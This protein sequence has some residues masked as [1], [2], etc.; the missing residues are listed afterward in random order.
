M[1]A[2][3]LRATRLIILGMGVALC[4]VSILHPTWHADGSRSQMASWLWAAPSGPPGLD[5]VVDWMGT[6]TRITGIMIG[7]AL[8]WW[9]I[10]FQIY[11][12]EN[13]HPPSRI[14][15]PQPADDHLNPKRMT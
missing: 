11:G 12:I 6:I 10:E 13:P 8:F 5:Y 4:L 2:T 14:V 7:N 3:K 9:T 1:R 15:S